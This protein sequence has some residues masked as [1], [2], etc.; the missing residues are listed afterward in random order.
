MATNKNQHFVPRCYL[1]PF[2]KDSANQAI[3]IFNIDRQIFIEGAPVKHQCS[4][5]YFYGE[6][7]KLESAL[8]FMEGSYASAL[9]EIH[10]PGYALSDG[11]RALMQRFWLLQF[12]RTEAASL[13]AVAMS[14]EMLN[15]AGI[16]FSEFKLQIRD[17]VIMAMRTYAAVMDSV[18]DLKVCL[19]KNKTSIPFVTSDDPAILSNRWYL[20]DQRVKGRSFGLRKAGN[21]FLLPLSPE[22]ACLGYD[23]DVY[24]VSHKNGWAEV[25]HEADVEAIN[26]HQFLNCRANIFIRDNSYADGVRE[27]YLKIAGRRPEA[28]HRIHYAVPDLSVGNHIRYTVVDRADAGPHEEALLHSETIH[29]MPSAWPRQIMWR[30]KGSVYTNGTG[31]GYVRR[32]WCEP[33]QNKPFWRESA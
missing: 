32:A 5:N 24:S 4:G 20:T 11:H 16:D 21:L 28:R 29:A 14:N 30:A 2:T 13:R 25:R 3:N 31:V 1:R 19:L 9:K 23:G 12:M 17:A 7:A 33:N 18:D 15:V 27:A 22:V 8:Q 10:K 26:Q 6:D